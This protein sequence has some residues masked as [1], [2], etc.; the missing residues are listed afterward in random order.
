MI[1][2]LKVHELEKYFKL[3]KVAY[4]P[5]EYNSRADLLLNLASTKK[6]GQN[7][8]LIQETLLDPT[9]EVGT[10]NMIDL[11]DITG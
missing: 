6:S 2:L 5:L 4:V 3:F 7:K 9:K 1:Y 10:I 11:G 8:T